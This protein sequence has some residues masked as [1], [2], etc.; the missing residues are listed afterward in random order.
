MR[1]PLKSSGRGFEKSSRSTW[2][3]CC[4]WPT[5]AERHIE[6]LTHHRPVKIVEEF[7]RSI[8]KEMD[9]TLEAT[10]MERVA[11]SFLHDETIYIPK[12]Y[13]EIT[14]KRVLTAEL[15]DGTKIS[16][17][18][19]L[20]QNGFDRKLITRRG[21]DILL[22]QIF[23]HGFFH[24]DP[25]PGNLFVLPNNVICLIDFGMMGSRGSPNP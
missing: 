1:L 19:Q 25:H 7:A 11:R 13:R 12:V 24:A 14:T 23:Q 17:L 16:R 9:Y 6:E 20:D 5:L 8:E 18:D 10:S 21:A 4:T 3:S 15:V 2:R 22:T